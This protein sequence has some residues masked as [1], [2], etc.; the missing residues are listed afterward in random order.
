MIYSIV[1]AFREG[2]LKHRSV[3]TFKYQDKILINAQP[4]NKYYQVILETDGYFDQ[5]RDS[6]LL[7]INLDVLGFVDKDEQTTQDIASQIGLSIINKVVNDNRNI[8]SL[9]GYTILLFTK[10]TDDNA[11]GARF[12]IRLAVPSFMDYCTEPSYFLDEEEYELKLEKMKSPDL[13]LGEQ[14]TNDRLDL[15]PLKI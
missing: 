12:T 14:N 8:M 11:A 5:K 15:N 2:A 6:H 13:D 4:N 7:T 10:S 3:W 1:E 9:E